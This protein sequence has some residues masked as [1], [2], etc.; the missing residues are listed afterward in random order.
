MS[1]SIIMNSSFSNIFHAPN[2]ASLSMK[3][4]CTPGWDTLEKNIIQQVFLISCS[5]LLLQLHPANIKVRSFTSDMAYGI[6]SVRRRRYVNVILI[7]LCV[8][9]MSYYVKFLPTKDNL[10]NSIILNSFVSLRG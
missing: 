9:C 1:M 4:P 10:F 2:T 6:M 7:I 8:L 3:S 5:L